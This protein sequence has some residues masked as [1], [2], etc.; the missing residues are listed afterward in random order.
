MSELS[1]ATSEITRLSSLLADLSDDLSV[2]RE[3][4]SS[5]SQ[6]LTQAKME[7]E[8]ASRM[9]GG[10]G[11]NVNVEYLKNVLLQYLTS[12]TVGEK[13]RLLPVLATVLSL[14]PAERIKAEKSLESN[15][16]I[17][18]VG[19]VLIEGVE[20]VKEEGIVKG[21]LGFVGLRR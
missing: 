11:D 12:Q 1:V 16:G 19:E 20:G 14:T 13:R 5:L 9:G 21:V 6:E 3:D 8:R 4:C 18:G 7:I 15:K 2:S 10:D 17:R